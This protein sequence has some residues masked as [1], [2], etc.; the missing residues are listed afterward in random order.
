M[1]I[2]DFIFKLTGTAGEGKGPDSLAGEEL[3]ST[4]NH[5]V[6]MCRPGAV[7]ESK[8]RKKLTPAVERSL[9]YAYDLVAQIPGPV[10]IEKDSWSKNPL[11]NALFAG[12]DQF[13][14]FFSRE[15][16]L[17][18]F[19]KKAGNRPC[20]ALL[21]MKKSEKTILVAEKQGEIFKRDVPKTAVNF[22][23]HRIVSP[24][25][26]EEQIKRELSNRTV[27][28]LTN[29]VCDEILE[30]KKWK[31]EL[32][33][34]KSLLEAQI[35]F[36]EAGRRDTE[37][38]F[39]EDRAEE[40]IRIVEAKNM[41]RQLDRKIAEI[42]SELPGSEDYLAKVENVLMHPEKYIRSKSVRMRIGDMGIKITDP[43]DRQGEEIRFSELTFQ[44][45]T[46]RAAVLVR[47]SGF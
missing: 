34:E 18:N 24:S 17:S 5:V 30:L 1:G 10:P 3:T 38:I 36:R 46:K 9:A 41:L 25:V 44:S 11:V 26:S 47:C 20:Y 35:E 29:M 14:E 15:K 2:L 28:L 37:T 33:Q 23:G 40:A 39:G 43:N 7:G 19:W 31:S 27:S 16:E 21:T 6:K 8:Y 12:N 32:E 45:G 4:I 42:R 13:K 22:D